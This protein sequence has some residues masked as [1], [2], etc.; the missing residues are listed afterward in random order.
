[1]KQID[2]CE[3]IR[4]FLQEKITGCKV[5]VIGDVMLDRYFFGAVER[6]SPEAP[7]PISLIEKKKDTLGGAGSVA[8]NLARLGCQ[9]CLAGLVAPDHHGRLLQRK[10]R[11]LGIEA[12]LLEGR[13][14]T[15]T[16][17]RVLGGH[18]QMIRLDFEERS[19]ITDEVSAQLLESVEKQMNDG[20]GAVIIS[21]YGKGV[22]TEKVCQ[23]IIRKAQSLGIVVL[24]DPKGRDW[25]RYRGA[26]Y[27]T[28]NVKETSEAVGTALSNTDD[29][30]REAAKSLMEKYALRNVMTTRSEKGL[31]LFGSGEE[32]TIPTVA[33]EVF[34][35]SGAGDTVIAAFAAGLAGGL[36]RYAAAYMANVAAGIGV[37]K[38]GTYAVSREEIME[39]LPGRQSGGVH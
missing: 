2:A 8:H 25:S 7:V 19:P 13:E 33:Q 5:M 31:S 12:G 35:V 21:D 15:T 34:D 14:E 20:L 11:N 18:Q 30:L 24:V 37:G 6:I 32:I 28:P 29:A 16:K 9:V 3:A 10:L 26:D 38:V 4:G 36:P 17:I 1:M 23:A 39:R 22:C 27:I